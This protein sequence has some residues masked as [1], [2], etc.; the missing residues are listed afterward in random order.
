[1]WA[2]LI[3]LVAVA[4]MGWAGDFH[5]ESAGARFGFSGW[6]GGSELYQAEGLVN[7]D[8]PWGWDLGREFWLQS[9]L[10][11]SAGRLSA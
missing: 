4:P 7:W 8:L 10:D 11:A 9:R 6:N 2:L 3:M 1:M 5:L